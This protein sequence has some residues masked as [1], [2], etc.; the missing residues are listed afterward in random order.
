MVTLRLLH[1]LFSCNLFQCYLSP[2]VYCYLSLLFTPSS[3]QVTLVTLPLFPDQAT[4][5]QMYTATS[6]YCSCHHLSPG[7]TSDAIPLS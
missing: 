3:L 1:V 5:L 7:H 2:N 4:S 6:L